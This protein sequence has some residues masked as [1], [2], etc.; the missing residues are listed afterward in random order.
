MEMSLQE[1]RSALAAHAGFDGTVPAHVLELL[2]ERGPW[3]GRVWEVFEIVA[4]NRDQMAFLSGGLRPDEVADGVAR[5]VESPLSV[6]EIRTV[7]EAGS[8]DPDPFGVLA[9]RG[10]LEAVLVDAEGRVRTIQGEPAGRWVADQ[11]ADAEDGAVLAWAER[12]VH[13]DA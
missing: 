7:I 11:F 9:A 2:S 3:S 8:Y 6:A 10:L 13:Q 5:W 12:F 1:L 4:A